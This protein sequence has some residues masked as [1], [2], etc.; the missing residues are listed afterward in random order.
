[1]PCCVELD[2]PPRSRHPAAL[3]P[4]QTARARTGQLPQ[5]SLFNVPLQVLPSRC[6]TPTQP[7]QPPYSVQGWVSGAPYRVMA[8]RRPPSTTPTTSALV[9]APPARQATRTREGVTRANVEPLGRRKTS[10]ATY[11][12]VRFINIRTVRCITLVGST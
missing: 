3:L 11:G 9:C 8:A 6:L 5:E 7:C 2:S 1:M 10:L 12:I 4:R